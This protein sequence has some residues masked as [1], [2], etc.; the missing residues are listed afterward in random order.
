[1]NVHLRSV[2]PAA[3]IAVTEMRQKAIARYIDANRAPRETI[4]RAH[5]DTFVGRLTCTI[6]PGPTMNNGTK[7][8]RC[9]WTLDNRPIST[10]GACLAMM[11]L[12]P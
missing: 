9:D 4:I 7:S 10:H 12:M 1:M 11:G 6:S 3:Q 5:E 2:T 8:F